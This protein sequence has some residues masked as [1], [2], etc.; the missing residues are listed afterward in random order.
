M[1]N[2]ASSVKAAEA[3]MNPRDEEYKPIFVYVSRHCKNK[4]TCVPCFLKHRSPLAFVGYDFY[5][6][7]EVD[8]NILAKSRP[9]SEDDE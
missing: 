9:R 8:I 3:R 4:P 1:G 6:T 2:L 5:A 7:D